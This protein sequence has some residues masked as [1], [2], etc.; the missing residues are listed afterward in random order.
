MGLSAT[1]LHNDYHACN[2]TLHVMPSTGVGTSG[3]RAPH[4]QLQIRCITQ[5]TGVLYNSV[6]VTPV[7][8]KLHGSVLV[9]QAV[10]SFVAGLAK[11]PT[12]ASTTCQ[13]MKTYIQRR[14]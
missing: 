6:R 4:T 12:T 7:M 5:P 14:C 13:Y 3:S 10:L 2:V 11:R 9:K 1:S 8:H